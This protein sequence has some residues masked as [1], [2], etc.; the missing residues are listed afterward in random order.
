[1]C[2]DQSLSRV[3]QTNLPSTALANA[4][5]VADGKAYIAAKEGRV[6][7]IDA[8][9]GALA[10]SINAG[11]P[12]TGAMVVQGDAIYVGGDEGVVLKLSTS[13]DTQAEEQR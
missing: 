2:F 1:M 13:V 7:C 5:V 3:W 8:A 4:P 11:E 12:I 6:W 9:S 10:G